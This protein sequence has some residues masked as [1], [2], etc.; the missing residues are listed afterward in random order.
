[1]WKSEKGTE[2]CGAEMQP[3]TS[4]PVYQPTQRPLR[5]RRWGIALRETRCVTWRMHRVMSLYPC[6]NQKKEQRSVGLRCSP[7]LRCLFISQPRD[8]C[9]IDDEGSLSGRQGVSPGRSIGLWVCN[10][11][12][13]RKRNRSEECAAVMQPFAS[14]PG[15]LTMGLAHR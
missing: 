10:R 1:M 2:E 11:V 15:Y 14:L 4:L 5:H 9:G 13:T 7:L 3:F 6:E 12:K 8:P